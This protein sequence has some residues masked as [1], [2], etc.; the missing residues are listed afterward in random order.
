MTTSRK[1]TFRSNRAY[2]S[3]A[4]ITSDIESHTVALKAM[5]EA[6]EIHERRTSNYL[7]SFVRVRELV[8]LGLITVDGDK[9]DSIDVPEHTHV[10]ADITD[11][12]N[13][14]VVGHTH[15][16]ADITDLDHYT[17]ADANAAIDARVTK[18]FVDALNVD[19][20]TLD[21][22]NSSSFVRSD[23]TDTVS[24]A[25]TFT[26]AVLHT[27]EIEARLGMNGDYSNTGAS[28]TWGANIWS[29]DDTW[30]GPTAGNSYAPIAGQYG[31]AWLRDATSGANA[32]A[33]EGLYIYRAGVNIAAIGRTS[34]VFVGDVTAFS[35]IRV[36]ED[37]QVIPDALDKVR[38]LSG[39][40]FFRSDSDR[41]KRRAGLIAQEVERVLPEVVSESGPG[42]MKHVAYGNVVALLIEAI[43]ELDRRIP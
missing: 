27:N 2:P 16:E 8:D 1:V 26:G 38:R 25:I 13:Y 20:D 43:K 24:G 35:D 17:D 31:L 34:A 32:A 21:G 15:T 10:E 11:L 29:L 33:D 4:S 36:K 39:Y 40:T 23:T 14:S 5:K 42:D 30:Q 12:G 18:A 7:D 6:I 3:I 22:I 9:F 37:L 19:A 28:N 41:R